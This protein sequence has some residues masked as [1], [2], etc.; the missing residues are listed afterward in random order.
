[1]KLGWRTRGEGGGI[2]IA[3]FLVKR[4][5]RSILKD[6]CGMEVFCGRMTS[7]IGGENDLCSS[8]K[9]SY[10][11]QNVEAAFR[12]KFRVFLDGAG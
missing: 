8:V 11:Q 1:M 6:M 12:N 9:V 10:L 7:V 4:L 3:G 5:T 2:Q